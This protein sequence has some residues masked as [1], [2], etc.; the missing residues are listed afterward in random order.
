M[1]KNTLIALLLIIA[2]G[3]AFSA[4]CLIKY[5]TFSYHDSDLGVINQ[6]M[7]NTLHG[8]PFYTSIFGCSILKLHPSL[9]FAV[10]LPLY[11]L[12]QS[13]LMLLYSQTFL[14]ALSGLPVYLV[15]R[16]ELENEKM[17]LL[18]MALYLLYPALG[19]VTLGHIEEQ[20]IAIFF[21]A[22]AY[23]FYRANR[24]ALFL[25][26]LGVALT[27]REEYSLIAIT[28]GLSA[29]W[30]RKGPKWWLPLC[31]GG[32]VWLLSYFFIIAPAIWGSAQSPFES[33]Y[34]EAGGSA[35]NILKNIVFHP[36]AIA[37]IMLT[38][39]KLLYLF[40]LL[41]PLAFI[42]L[43]SP[44][45][46]FI[47]SPVILLNL[48]AT[49]PWVAS[50]VNKYNAPVI[51]FVFFASIAALARL[52]RL[53]SGA[54]NR[55]VVAALC[56]AG[57]ASAWGWGPQ[58]H[59]LSRSWRGLAE[60]LPKPDFLAPYKQEM[61]SRIPPNVPAATNFG[62][63]AHL[64]SRRDLAAVP[65]IVS[66]KLGPL[67]LPYFSPPNTEYALIDLGDP[68]T[69]VKFYDPR[70]SAERFRRFLLDNRLGLVALYDQIALF[71]RDAPDVLPLYERVKEATPSKPMAEFEGL[72][73]EKARLALT[74][75]APRRQIV[76]T[77]TWR[78]ARMLGDDL[79]AMILI[80]DAEGISMFPHQVRN[81]CQH[82][83]PTWE[84][85]VGE[86][87]R[88]NHL[89]ALPPSLP[90]GRY[91]LKM[92]IINKFPPCRAMQC[93]A[94]VR[95]IDQNGWFIAAAI[96]I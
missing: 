90:P 19:Y 55:A 9:I 3:V 4:T 36:L 24:Y 60:L 80:T 29:L 65:W 17:G 86:T 91:F 43:L 52:R 38:P 5:R 92:L 57:G 87:I 39:P 83:F 32:C 23:Y 40:H 46:L 48:L 77:S 12:W 95:R 41:A 30:E 21:L 89:I 70:S 47:I 28:F 88:A 15:A 27:G 25:I 14:L 56:I 34:A 50:I 75:D 44:R 85:P 66:G 71:K 20:T 54:L 6:V 76:F 45:V 73:L 26:M 68:T 13:P 93:T 37:S 2:Y 11:A 94:D 42:P 74:G 61:V 84:W 82:L 16:R 10:F 18:F 96:D 22:W 63:F 81:I 1:K 79:S 35:G 31:A 7:W 78:A 69:F 33:F 51:P 49:R 62:F 53:G 58:M 67:P 59:L 8:R 64:S 72:E